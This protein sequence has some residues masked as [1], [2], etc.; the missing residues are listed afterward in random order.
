MIRRGIREVGTLLAALTLAAGSAA[1][2][3][4]SRAALLNGSKFPIARAVTVPPGYVLTFHS[5]IT[6]S[7]K[8]PGAAP[9]SPAYW[10][11]TKAQAIS[12]FDNIR[13]SLDDLG[14]GFGDVVK[15]T[16]FLVADPAKG[17]GRMDFAGFM[18]AYTQYFGTAQ[19]P[20]LPARSAVQVAGLAVPGMLVEVEVV[21]ASRPK[22]RVAH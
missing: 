6:P 18:E 9:G 3:D 10:G 12:V 19:Q 11:D 15:M 16:V 13:T 21:L 7:P 14:L 1:G 4:I 17:D 5:G 22:K 2:Q 20:A 8:D